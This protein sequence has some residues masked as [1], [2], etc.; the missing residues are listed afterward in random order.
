MMSI[1]AARPRL[2]RRPRRL[3]DA[4]VLDLILAMG[5]VVLVCL[6]GTAI[7]LMQQINHNFDEELVESAH[8]L[9]DVAMHQIERDLGDP[10]QAPPQSAP[11][12]YRP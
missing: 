6:V 10:P 3:A 12:A 11:P 8:R 1:H 4:L 7:F 2:P 5:A 9:M